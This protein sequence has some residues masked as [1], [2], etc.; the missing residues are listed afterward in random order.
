ML[1]TTRAALPSRRRTTASYDLAKASDQLR[2]LLPWRT[3]GQGA[4]TLV[5][6]PELRVVL[7]ELRAGVRL[8]EHRTVARVTVHPL[9][10][11]IRLGVREQAIDVPAGQLL[12]LGPDV[13]H[14]VEAIEDS[15]ILLTLAWPRGGTEKPS[16]PG[17]AP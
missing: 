16:P 9:R 7:L 8:L 15:T 6:Q 4:V 12:V 1:Q 13:A 14:D 5:R 10:G 2:A 3:H 17:G 11:R